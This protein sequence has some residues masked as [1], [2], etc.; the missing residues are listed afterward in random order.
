MLQ[1][2]DDKIEIDTLIESAASGE[3]KWRPH[4]GLRAR[5]ATGDHKLKGRC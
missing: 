3:T 1:I 2:I 5:P 4:Y